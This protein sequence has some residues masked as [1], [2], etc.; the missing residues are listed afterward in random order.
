MASQRSCKY[1]SITI[2]QTHFKISTN[3][4]LFLQGYV[5]TKHEA[6]KIISFERAELLFIF[7]FHPTKSYTDYRVGVELPGTYKYLLNSDDTEFGGFNRIDTSVSHY[8]FDE[9]WN[10]RRHSLQVY[11]PCRTCIVLGRN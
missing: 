5:S 10:G 2:T 7:N 4:F 8:T 9:G 1:F 11:I 6:D 3:L